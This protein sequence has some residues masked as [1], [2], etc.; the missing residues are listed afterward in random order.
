[1]PLG[2]SRPSGIVLGRSN[3]MALD[4]GR[5][6][7]LALD[8]A[9][10]AASARLP[11][12]PIARLQLLRHAVLRRKLP[13]Q[14]AGRHKVAGGWLKRAGLP[15]LFAS[16]YRCLVLI[17][18]SRPSKI[19]R[20]FSFQKSEFM[21]MIFCSPDWPALSAPRRPQGDRSI[22]LKETEGE[23]IFFI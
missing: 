10:A 17:G 12:D 3:Y 5:R 8:A 1:M 11:G 23:G 14:F 4:L 19:P 22:L 13:P 15:C 7:Q 16:P 20:A 18:A 9:E 6:G 2:R 21:L